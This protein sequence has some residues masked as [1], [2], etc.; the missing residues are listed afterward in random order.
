M[1]IRNR[2]SHYWN[3]G[4]AIARLARTGNNRTT[5]HQPRTRV[6]DG[7]IIRSSA[8]HLERHKRLWRR[9]LF[10]GLYMV[11]IVGLPLH[12]ARTVIAST[13]TE[14]PNG[15]TAIEGPTANDSEVVLNIWD[16]TKDY[17]IDLAAAGA[18][19]WGAWWVWIK[20]QN[21]LTA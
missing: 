20:L 21:T 2:D 7:T 10:M 11:C 16:D 13:A 5:G 8:R 17:L 9:L 4:H 18:A 3:V 1:D 6:P 12:D 14:M 15:A 19:L